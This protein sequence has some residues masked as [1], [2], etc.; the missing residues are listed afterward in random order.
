[1]ARTVAFSTSA[2]NPAL[3]CFN[4]KE[5]RRAFK[6]ILSSFL[7]EWRHEEYER[8][9]WSARGSYMKCHFGTNEIAWRSTARDPRCGTLKWIILLISKHCNIF[10]VDSLRVFVIILKDVSVAT[11]K[12]LPGDNIQLPYNMAD[13]FGKT[14]A[15][16][17]SSHSKE[18]GN[19][20]MM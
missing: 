15:G 19:E 2:I 20:F 4:N 7:F 12:R 11:F 1:V 13:A 6:T 16:E 5:Y 14:T 10:L 9:L 18:V 8:I 17:V 3:Y